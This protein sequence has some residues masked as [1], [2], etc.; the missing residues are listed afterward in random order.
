MAK[1]RKAV[2]ARKAKVRPA[3]TTARR[4]T[5]KGAAAKKPVRKA[6]KRRRKTKSKSIGARLEHAP[7]AVLETLTD[8]ERLH[9]RVAAKGVQELE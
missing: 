2:K 1:K 7:E 6:A 9:T 8:A 4:K 3:R 5:V